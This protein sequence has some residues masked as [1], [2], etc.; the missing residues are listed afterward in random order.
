MNKISVVREIEQYLPNFTHDPLAIGDSYKFIA[1]IDEKSV[2]RLCELVTFLENGI[3]KGMNNDT[4][5]VFFDLLIDCDKDYVFFLDTTNQLLEMDIYEVP[6]S[7]RR[8]TRLREKR[9]ANM[10]ETNKWFYEQ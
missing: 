9:I 8:S 4:G 7:V 2:E 10:R 6:Q 1:A 5:E 3:P